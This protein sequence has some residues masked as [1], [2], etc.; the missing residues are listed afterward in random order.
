MP[1][2]FLKEAIFRPRTIGAILPS[3]RFLARK[4]VGQLK[5]HEAQ[6]VVEY[7]PGT[8]ALTE[9]IIAEKQAHTQLILIEANERFAARLE[10]RFSNH[11]EIHVVHD[12]AASVGEIL[13]KHGFKHADCIISGLPFS[14]LPPK[15][16]DS[17]LLATHENLAPH[18]HF[19]L[20]QYTRLKLALFARYFKCVKTD[21][22]LLNIPPAF[23]LTYKRK[24]LTGH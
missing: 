3:S 11:K 15:I 23:V 2:T 8:G 22:I 17:I 21:H 7:G 20:F 10:A 24:A 1:L 18:G 5:L 19:V 4:M 9:A 6:C 16:A 12:S 14:S 13:K